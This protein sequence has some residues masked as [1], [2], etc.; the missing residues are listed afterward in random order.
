MNVKTGFISWDLNMTM[1]NVEAGRVSAEEGSEESYIF[2]AF[3]VLNQQ[4][5]ATESSNLIYCYHL[6][7]GVKKE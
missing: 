5:D 3:L 7:V 1:N 4:H 6:K 2:S